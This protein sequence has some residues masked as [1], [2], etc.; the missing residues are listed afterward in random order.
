MKL[1]NLG[2]LNRIYNFQDTIIFCE[3]FEQRSE[4]LQEIFKYN[5]RKCNSA[6]SFSG[7]IHCNKSKCSIAL[8]T[9]PEFIRIFEKTLIGG[10]NCV[11]SRLA[12]GTD[13]LL[14]NP[15]SEKVLI[16]IEKEKGEKQL[17]RFSSKIVEMDENNQYG[18]AMTKLCLTAA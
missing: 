7:W 6:S 11:N 12:F 9:D 3:I 5:S 8:P 18:Q 4:L 1:K 17:K 15:S 16:E 14:K 10:S 2:E 13:I